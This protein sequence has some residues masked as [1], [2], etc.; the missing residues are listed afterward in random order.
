MA[1]L[2]ISANDANNQKIGEVVD[3]KDDGHMWGGREQPPNYVHLT[4]TG[5]TRT[6]VSGYLGSWG[7][8]FEHTI[9]NQNANGYRIRVEVD[10]A[11]I[12]ASNQ[13]KAGLKSTMQ[14]WCENEYGCVGVSFTSDSMTVDVPKTPPGSATVTSADKGVVPLST[15]KKDFRDIF[16]GTFDARRYKFDPVDVQDAI[17]NNNGKIT[18]TRA[19]AVNNVIDKLTL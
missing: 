16:M 18:L 3:V 12:S 10:P 7:I 15:M 1:E 11:Y 14:D 13:G 8:D 2:L 4:V 9:V 6:Q 17:N 19:Q 5:A